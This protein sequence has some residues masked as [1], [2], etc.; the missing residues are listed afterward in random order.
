MKCAICHHG[1]TEPDKIHVTLKRD[2]TILVFQNVPAQVCD[3]CGEEYLSSETNHLLLEQ[4]NR[5]FAHH[6]LLSLLDFVA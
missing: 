5:S 4:A 6:E 3:N 2:N 1:Q